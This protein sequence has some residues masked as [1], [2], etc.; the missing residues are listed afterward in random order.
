MKSVMQQEF[1]T[2]KDVEFN[3]SIK[4]VNAKYDSIK[5]SLQSSISSA[6]A[7]RELYINELSRF[8]GHSRVLT[9]DDLPSLFISL[10]NCSKLT[11]GFNLVPLKSIIQGIFINQ[12]IPD[13]P[14]EFFSVVAMLIS[15]SVPEQFSQVLPTMLRL[16]LFI[17][18]STIKVLDSFKSQFSRVESDRSTEL[19]IINARIQAY[20]QSTEYEIDHLKVE[21]NYYKS[22]CK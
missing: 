22:L 16:L 17:N 2:S 21:L 9:T 14:E 20:H 5:E 1:L 7:N 3:N 10:G 6:T 18:Q 4:E 19:S 13:S 15:E 8:L 11:S 12:S